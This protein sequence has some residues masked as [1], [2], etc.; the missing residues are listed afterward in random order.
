VEVTPGFAV[1]DVGASTTLRVNAYTAGGQYLIDPA[2]QWG[3]L[4]PTVAGVDA[5]GRVTAASPGQARIVAGVDAARDTATIAALGAQSVLSTAFAGGEARADVWRGQTIIVPVVLDLSRVS[6]NGDLGAAQ[7]ELRFDPA[8]LVFQSATAGV[9]GQ[10]EHNVPAPGTF[11][12]SFAATS[13]QGSARLTL[14]TIVFQVAPGA[15]PG[16]RHALG[17]TYTAQPAKTSFAKYALP[18]AVGGRVKVQ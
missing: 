8:V 15:A 2:V 5:G 6:S 10:A 9:T 16:T 14:V 4:S 7:F 12:F 1:L 18:I 13:P 17:L 3:S 11:R